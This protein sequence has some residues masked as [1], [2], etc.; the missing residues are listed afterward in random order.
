MSL[1]RKNIGISQ[2]INFAIDNDI[3]FAPI[4]PDSKVPIKDWVRYRELP[5]EKAIIPFK[6]RTKFNIAFLCGSCSDNL[7]V[8]DCD[9]RE[10][11]LIVRDVLKQYFS[12][13]IFKMISS[14]PHGGFHLFFKC[15]EPL[16][17]RRLL[18]IGNKVVLDRQAE[19]K[20]VLVSP[21]QVDGKQYRWVI[22]E[23]PR[24][25]KKSFVELVESKIQ[26]LA[27]KRGYQRFKER[28]GIVRDYTPNRDCL[29][30]R[31]KSKI[32]IL[33]IAKHFG[34]DVQTGINICPFHPDTHPSL[35]V[36]PD[37]ILFHC[38]G[39]G[40]SGDIFDF[41]ALC[42]GIEL[43]DEEGNV[44]KEEFKVVLWELKKLLNSK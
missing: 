20:Y 38:F 26:R 6:S 12:Q 14:T 2:T 8:W 31:L 23:E 44:K 13:N 19:G 18:K 37:G 9:T 33:D 7:F 1:S 41:Y 29:A 30:E 4:L 28:K 3:K 11:A 10:V 39:C 5:Y 35:S 40:A 43:R 25:L 22:L 24:I 32:T 17:S 27:E 42:R 16:K 15:N 36:S 21:S 34:L